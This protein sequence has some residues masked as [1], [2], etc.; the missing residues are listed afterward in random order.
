MKP[1]D[2]RSAELSVSTGLVLVEYLS[3][4]S[5]RDGAARHPLVDDLPAG[6]M[7]PPHRPPPTANLKQDPSVAS[8]R[9]RQ[10]N[11]FD[12]SVRDDDHL[13]RARL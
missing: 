3:L 9:R 12:I 4:Q 8:S 11:N 7:P 10:K 1:K 2:S 6:R 5:Q 13:V